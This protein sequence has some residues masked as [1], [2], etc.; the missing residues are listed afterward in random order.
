[1][2]FFWILI[3]WLLI[4]CICRELSRRG[5][6]SKYFRLTFKMFL[7]TLNW[8][9]ERK[10]SVALLDKNG[11]NNS[12]EVVYSACRRNFPTL[13]TGCEDTS[14]TYRFSLKSFITSYKFGCCEFCRKE[15]IW[16]RLFVKVA[17]ATKFFI[18]W[19]TAVPRVP[20]WLVPRRFSVNWFIFSRMLLGQTLF[21]SFLTRE[22]NPKTWIEKKILPLTST[23]E[24]FENWLM[25][26]WVLSCAETF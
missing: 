20:L 17:D 7:L 18:F 15:K 4:Q 24:S 5:L 3:L 23:N 1:M 2:M 9:T 6:H 25:T 19:A 14:L 22:R 12:K 13:N 16:H 11:E 8:M 10:T 21:G 26:S